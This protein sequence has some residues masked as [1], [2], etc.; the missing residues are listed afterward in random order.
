M[1]CPSEIPIPPEAPPPLVVVAGSHYDAADWQRFEE[2]ADSEIAW[3]PDRAP[4]DHLLEQEAV[5]LEI[6]GTTSQTRSLATDNKKPKVQSEFWRGQTIHKFAVAAK[7]RSAGAAEE[8]DKLENCH[9]YYTVAQCSECGSVRKFPNRCDLFYCPECQPGLAYDRKREISWWTATLRQPKHVVLTVRNIPDLTPGHVTQLRRWF[10]ALRRRKFT[11]GW[12]GGFYSIE[13]TNEGK[14]WHLHIHALV[15]ARWIDGGELALVWDSITNGMGRIVKVRD[16]RGDQYLQ[17]VTKY[18]AKGSEMATWTPTE[19]L[20]FIRAFKGKRT[21][22]VFGS[23]Y[24]ARTEF[25]EFIATL[26]AAKPKCECGSISCRYF[27]ET[28]WLLQELGS[29]QPAATRPPPAAQLQGTFR[30]EREPWPD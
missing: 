7:L 20:A 24:G 22:G 17:E 19:C 6:R 3:D 5:K 16:C 25:A 28:D 26:K 13:C 23:L 4:A 14:G 29:N 11:K 15:E 27:S 21:F 18:V 8:A 2:L 10:T 12:S 9:S 1:N 30:L